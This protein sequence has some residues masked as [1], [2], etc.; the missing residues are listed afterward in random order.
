[1]PRLE[2]Q[3][4]YATGVPQLDY[5][6]R[7]ILD[8]VNFGCDSLR[9]I[10]SRDEVRDCLESLYAR[11]SAHFALEEDV[12][13]EAHYELY[14]A[15]KAQ[16]EALV[17]SLRVMMDSFDDGACAQCKRSLDDCLVEWFEKHFQGEDARLQR[18][19]HEPH[20]RPAG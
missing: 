1:M 20:L 10:T 11:V 7:Q 17:D 9:D 3:A 19:R 5:E 16:H 6:H 12:M 8:L 18:L 14:A 15:H 13:R 2:W 4:A